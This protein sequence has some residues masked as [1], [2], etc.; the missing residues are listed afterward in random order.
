MTM[1]NV[2]IKL[3]GSIKFREKEKLLWKIASSREER[4]YGSVKFIWYSNY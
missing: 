1:G 3:R 4:R 2:L